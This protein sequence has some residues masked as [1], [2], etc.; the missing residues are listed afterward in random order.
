[1]GSHGAWRW[2]LKRAR[3][4]PPRRLYLRF[5]ANSRGRW[6]LRMQTQ[7]DLLLF[8]GFTPRQRS[9]DAVAALVA[10][11]ARDCWSRK[12][13]ARPAKVN[14]SGLKPPPTHGPIRLKTPQPSSWV[15]LPNGP[16]VAEIAFRNIVHFSSWVEWRTKG[17]VSC[18]F[19]DDPNQV[20]PSEDPPSFQ[21][22][23]W[24]PSS[25]GK[26]QK[27]TYYIS[28][29]YVREVAHI[30]GYVRETRFNFMFKSPGALEAG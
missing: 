11:A 3:P 2:S 25:L 23:A 7:L 12:T 18:Q 10:Y 16:S 6:R 21:A 20:W 1:M 22:P 14:G 28:L 30:I 26:G 24:F 17:H 13:W 29:E 9:G 19:N 5:S 4:F 8:V 15:V 27:C